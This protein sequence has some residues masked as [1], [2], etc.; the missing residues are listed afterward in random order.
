MTHETSGG[1]TLP[2]NVRLPLWQGRQQVAAL[3]LSSR[4]LSAGQRE[5]RLLQAWQPGCRAWRFDDGDLLC[6]PQPQWMDCG[7]ADGLPLCQV[8]GVLQAGPLTVGERARI[9][10]ADLILVEGAQALPRLLAQGE[11]LDLSLQLD[12]SHYTLLDPYDLRIPEE[13]PVLPQLE[14]K[15]MRALLGKAIPPRSEASEQFLRVL[16]G[17]RHV[18][19]GSAVQR[20]GS[21]LRDVASGLG[22][23]LLSQ[24][25]QALG[26]GRHRA[27]GPGTGIAARRGP[28]P[29][30]PWRMA[31]GRLAMVTRASRLFGYR[32]GA[33]LRRMMGMFER[34]DLHEALRHALPLDGDGGS[35]GPA[36]GTPG[37]RASLTVGGVRS[38]AT[39]INLDDALMQHLRQMY[40]AAFERLDRAGRIDEAVFVLAELLH[41]RQEALDYLVRHG[42]QAQAAELALGWDMSPATVIRLL[43]LAG[44]LPRAVLVARRD[45][46]FSDAI[47]LLQPA[48]AALADTLRSQWAEL[49]ARHGDWLGAVE[50]LWPIDSARGQALEWLLAAERS[51]SALS[52][53]ALVQRAALLPATLVDHAPRIEAL[54]APSGDAQLRMAMAD[55]LLDI[56]TGNATL[57]ALASHLLPVLAADR[58]LGNAHWPQD[59]FQRLLKL[60]ANPLLRA[61]IPAWQAPADAP[62][63]A[64]LGK[65]RLDLGAPP[66]GLHRLHDLAALPGGRYLVALGEAGAV[67]IDARGQVQQRFAVPAMRLVMGDSGELAL[68]V[69]PREQVSRVER[70]DLATGRVTAMGTLASGTFAPSFGSVG[71]TVLL[72]NRIRVVDASRQVNDLLWHVDLPGRVCAAGFFA[73]SE[74]YLIETPAGMESWTYR[75]PGRRRG[76][77]HPQM[78]MEDRVRLAAPGGA[79]L[80]P[81]VA[82][83]DSGSLRLDYVFNG[84]RACTLLTAAGD[85]Q[86]PDDARFQALDCGLFVHLFGPCMGISL[87]LRYHDAA[88]LAKVEWPGRAQVVVREQPGALLLHDT[89][90]RW[91]HIDTRTGASHGMQLLH[92]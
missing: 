77:H 55:A 40:R 19:R 30:S 36:F 16:N 43:M 86:M 90:G 45:N 82:L 66:A 20:A 67:V 79:L 61:D 15:S 69:A 13:Q 37:R 83:D 2:H 24:A 71:W 74:V 58:S 5:T 35:L 4:W 60:S 49:R 78:P 70:L 56:G 10:A 44:D 51:G 87:L 31:L 72:D 11:P 23:S 64:P 41:V 25:G 81:R 80:Q 85:G 1:S 88:V 62:A 27:V 75:L 54:L 33:H 91:V 73:E 46:A 52:V 53:R 39:N 84:P 47:A 57:Q 68:A 14:G 17:E 22:L 3:W 8:E 42:R 28:T 76:P 50:T 63:A 12:V 7:C 26:G 48:D 18:P 9:P 34:G 21:W 92:V 65:G 29:P 38:A 32:Q 89:G 59:R 6:L